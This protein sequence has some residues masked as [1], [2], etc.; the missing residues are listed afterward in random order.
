MK[1][2]R[3]WEVGYKKENGKQ[4]RYVGYMRSENIQIQQRLK[5]A[6]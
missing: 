1:E 4:G 6:S 3:K 2:K 5:T